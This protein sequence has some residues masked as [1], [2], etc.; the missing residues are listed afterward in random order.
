ME[1]IGKHV[2]LRA[3]TREDLPLYERWLNDPDLVA[4]IQGG[5]TQPITLER[6]VARFEQQLTIDKPEIQTELGYVIADQTDLNHANKAKYWRT[7]IEQKRSIVFES[8]ER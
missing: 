8:Q 2:K 6:L 4:L 7:A 1:L 5:I 3:K